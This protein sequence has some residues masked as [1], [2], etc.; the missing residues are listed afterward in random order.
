MWDEDSLLPDNST[1]VFCPFVDTSTA[2]RWLA[3][4]NPALPVGPVQESQFIL[5][6]QSTVIA[7][8]VAPLVYVFVCSTRLA[9]IPTTLALPGVTF[10]GQ[11]FNV[12]DV[13]GD[14]AT[15]NVIVT[16]PAIDQ[17][18]SFTF[19]ANYQGQNFTWNGSEWSAT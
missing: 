18:P 16:A 9:N 15:Y 14:A 17:Q 10:I 3:L 19:Y 1:S 5:A 11:T 2:G 7:A 13:V 6:G 8:S 4:A 12:K